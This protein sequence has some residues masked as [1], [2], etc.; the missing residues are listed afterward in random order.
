VGPIAAS[1][2][3][4]PITAGVRCAVRSREGEEPGATPCRAG[5]GAG[6]GRE[7]GISRP[8]PL[9]TMVR[10]GDGMALAV[11]VANEHR[12][13]FEPAAG[14]AGAA[15]QTLQQA[16]A[17]TIK[18]AKGRRMEPIKRSTY[19]FCQGERNDV[20]LS[21]SSRLCPL[22]LPGQCSETS[23]SAKTGLMHRSNHAHG[24]LI[25]PPHRRSREAWAGVLGRNLFF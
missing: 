2:H 11:I 13:G 22:C 15:R 5:D 14:R 23:F 18:A 12:A 19:P 17:F 16:Q 4:F 3:T 24:L 7:A 25:R 10:N 21:L 1:T 9:E 8:L 20:G 6:N